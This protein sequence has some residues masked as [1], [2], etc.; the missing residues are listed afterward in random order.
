MEGIKLSNLSTG[1]VTR[2]GLTQDNR[3]GN[4]LVSAKNTGAKNEVSTA[5]TDGTAAAKKIE[6]VRNRDQ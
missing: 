1:F 3:R 4:G 5:G 6:R 2:T